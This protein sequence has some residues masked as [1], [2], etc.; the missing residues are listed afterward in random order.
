[1]AEALAKAVGDPPPED[2]LDRSLPV[3]QDIS[4]GQSH[5]PPDSYTLGQRPFAGDPDDA[6]QQAAHRI[7]EKFGS[8][9]DVPS[10]IGRG[11]QMLGEMTSGPYQVAKKILGGAPVESVTGKDVVTLGTIMVPG[12]GRAASRMAP[13][14][15]GVF[16]SDPTGSRKVTA[17][18]KSLEGNKEF[19]ALSNAILNELVQRRRQIMNIPREQ[20]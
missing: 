4:V 17:L 11:A 2:V 12:Y 18:V 1:M 14:E 7:A 13:G 10:R 20:W 16:G 9:Q 6:T 5:V 15:L 3:G 8:L 19:D